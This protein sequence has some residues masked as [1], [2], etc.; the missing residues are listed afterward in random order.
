MF[1]GEEELLI[2]MSALQQF[3]ANVDNSVVQLAHE[4]FTVPYVGHVELELEHYI[5]NKS[6]LFEVFLFCSR[7]NVHVLLGVE[8]LFK[9]GIGISGFNESIWFSSWSET[10]RSHC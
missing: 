9:L 5:V 7:M 4:V 6:Y 1:V 8:I 2:N 10:T 3:S